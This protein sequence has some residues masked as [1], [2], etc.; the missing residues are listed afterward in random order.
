MAR[1]LT[2]AQQNRKLQQAHERRLVRRR[3]AL[4]AVMD[5]E[6]GRLL[7]SE[8]IADCGVLQGQFVPDPYRL[9][10]DAGERNAGLRLM[11][12][13]QRDAPRNFPLMADEQA[14]RAR[15]DEREDEA[16]T[17]EAPGGSES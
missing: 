14:Q 5:T 10:F 15:S 8:I 12:E 4:R 11:A 17:K 16:A 13:C 2:D 7:L 9:Y 1:N 6:P 3:D